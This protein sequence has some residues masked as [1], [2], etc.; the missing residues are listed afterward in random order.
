M[1]DNQKTVFFLKNKKIEYFHITFLKI[2]LSYF[3]LFFE[4]YFKK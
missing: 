4:N 2:V 1:F 3:H